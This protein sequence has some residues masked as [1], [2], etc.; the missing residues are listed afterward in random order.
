M[1]QCAFTASHFQASQAGMAIL[2]DGG[3]A[4]EAMV[5]AA[6]A[7]AVA[8]PHMNSL[9]GDGF[10]LIHE[11]GKAPVAINAAGVSAEQA[12]LGWYAQKGYQTIPSRGAD[13][14]LTVA[15]TVAGWNAALKL[16]AQWQAPM[17]LNSLF[18]DA[19]HLAKE[20]IVV[21][22]SLVAASRKTAKEFSEFSAFCERYLPHQQTL[23]A[24]ELLKNGPLAD[25]LTHLSQAGLD[26][27]YRG[28]SAREIAKVLSSQGSPLTLNDLN[29]YDAAWVEPL[30][31]QTSQGTFYNLP[32]P[33]QGIAS[34]LILAIFDRLYDA[35]LD[36]ATQL[37]LLIEA[38]KQAFRVRNAEAQDPQHTSKNI[39]RWLTETGIEKL[40][41]EI[42]L[43]QAAPWPNP[44]IPGDT[45]WMGA[46]DK[47]GRMVSFIQSIYW[48]FGSGV[49]IPEL[50]LL[51]N[52][53]GVSFSLQEG[54]TNQ[55]RGGIQPFHTL[56]PAFAQ[57]NDGRNMVYGTM[58]GEGQP[59]T[60][61]AMIWRHLYQQ[62]SLAT[63]IAEPRWL[64]GR[65]WGD[66]EHD[67]KIES[68]LDWQLQQTLQQQG[69]QIKTVPACSELMGHAGAITAFADH[70][71]QVATD[72][73]SDG[74]A[75]QE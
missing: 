14:A 72:P 39:E 22:E 27:F 41:S 45:I 69:H 10:W 64:L 5:A 13:A 4:I 74:A 18:C 53:R 3:T 67:L 71:D 37:H 8:Y 70:V 60:Q 17:G 75:L 59:Q 26:D 55:L 33:T 68:D 56:N 16:S 20:G 73:R 31:V 66:N 2:R 34:L 32:L 15:G 36:E 9:G 44:A 62:K 12:T 40:A 46:R 52:N 49:V 11:P 38:T 57:L 25:F 19:I 1:N 47:E 54:A 29:R 24:G 65:T 6:A 35:S 30:S 63:S 23:V 43:K 51:W 28:E 21:T 58:G 61:A 42:N 48:E 50:G 7:I